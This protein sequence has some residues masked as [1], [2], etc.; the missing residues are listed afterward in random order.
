MSF[1]YLFFVFTDFL[2]YSRAF[3]YQVWMD[4]LCRIFTVFKHMIYPLIVY[5]QQ[6]EQCIQ[7]TMGFQ[8]RLTNNWNIKHW[9]TNGISF[10]TYV[11]QLKYIELILFPSYSS[12]HK[13]FIRSFHSWYCCCCCYFYFFSLSLHAE[14]LWINRFTR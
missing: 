4:S 9:I 2:I 11:V 3:P 6:K 7:N 10:G 12:Y 1:K 14:V 8:Q 5:V 13:R